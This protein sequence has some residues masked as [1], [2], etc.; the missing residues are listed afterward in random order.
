[1]MTKMGCR[2][3]TDRK[4]G[5]YPYSSVQANVPII[6]ANQ[7]I[8]W[9]DDLIQDK[10]IYSPT[11]DLIHGREEEIHI[12]VLYGIHYQTSEQ[13]ESILCR[14]SSF[15]VKLGCISIFTTNQDFDVVKIEVISPGLFY[16]NHLLKTTVLNTPSYLSYKPHAT[17]AYVKKDSYNHLIGK[18]DFKDWRWTN[19]SVI[20]SSTNGQKTPIRLNTLK[21]VL[22]S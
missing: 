19:N 13:T 15:E 7:I 18:N 21:P 17:I 4:L 16:L 14:Q 5:L 2:P 6:I 22:C 12:T 9:G 1:M 10:D 8:Q 3:F 11:N 20:F